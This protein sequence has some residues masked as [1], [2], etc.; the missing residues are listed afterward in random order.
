MVISMASDV[1]HARVAGLFTH[2]SHVLVYIDNIVITRYDTF[3]KHLQD[4]NNIFDVLCKSGFILTIKGMKPQPEQSSRSKK[5]SRR[6]IE[7]VKTVHQD[8][9]LL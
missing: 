2:F 6:K 7:T 9:K 3:N 8:D 1:L 5:S 4:V